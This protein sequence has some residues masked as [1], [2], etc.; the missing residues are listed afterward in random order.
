M[1][2]DEEVEVPDPRPDPET[3][4]SHEEEVAQLLKAIRRLS[5]DYR[6]VITL[7]LEGMSYAEIAE[8]VGIGESN[9]GVRLNRAPDVA[10]VA[11]GKEMMA[12]DELAVWRRQWTSQPAVPV[13]LIRKVE[14]QTAYMRML[15]VA[16][17]LV[18]VFAGGAVIAA[19]IVHPFVAAIYWVVL[20][21]GT[22]TF[23]AVG[24]VVSL[25]STQGT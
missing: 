21:L 5:F 11:G 20:A 4:L 15:R 12:D 3:V 24:W 13:D 22:W 14:R 8:V 17:V 23:I 18:T 1:T 16:E 19:A 2:S 7:A 10:D 6:Q 9:V 25:R